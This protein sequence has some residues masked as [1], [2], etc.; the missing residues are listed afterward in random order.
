MVTPHTSPADRALARAE[1]RKTANHHTA[2]PCKWR[3]RRDLLALSIARSTCEQAWVPS[4]AVR[5]EFLVADRLASIELARNHVVQPSLRLNPLSC[6]E[7]FAP[8]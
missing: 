8:D 1:L 6:A 3:A 5:Y 7:P 4:R 2:D